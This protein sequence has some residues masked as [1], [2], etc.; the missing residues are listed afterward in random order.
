MFNASPQRQR[1]GPVCVIEGCSNKP[2]ARQL[3]AKHYQHDRAIRNG[4]KQCARKACTSLALLDGLCMPHYT[5]RK[6][7]DEL[8]ELRD[9]RR[10][11]VDGCDRPFDSN[12]LCQM[13]YQRLRTTGQV[14]PA[15]LLRGAN[16]TGCV[17][18]TGYRVVGNGAGRKV[19]EHRVVME[20]ILGR[21]L[22]REENVHH[23]NGDRLD[24][25]PENLELWNTSQP[26]GQRVAD[27]LAWAREIL[28]LYGETTVKG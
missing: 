9:S 2:H 26:S 1:L 15:T 3:C 27:K 28:A 4:S 7:T 11:S 13:H 6:R 25:R 22:L 20:Q 10:C 19:A 16:G 18:S 23:I 5:K 14:G 12:D 8:K 21:P 17:T 24:N